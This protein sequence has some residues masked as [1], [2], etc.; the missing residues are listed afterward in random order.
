[1]QKFDVVNLLAEKYGYR[2]YLEISTPG[3]SNAY[4]KIDRRQMFCRRLMYRCAETFRD[5]LD[6]AFRT[7]S[8]YSYEV[9][10]AILKSNLSKGFYD[11]AFVDSFGGHD[12]SL[13]DILGAYALARPGGVIVV[14]NCNPR[15]AADAQDAA[16]SRAF[17]DFLLAR[18]SVTAYTVDCDN[19][20][21]VVFKPED[22]PQGS[23]ELA[24]DRHM[25]NLKDDPASFAF[26]DDKR[27]ELLRLVNEDGFVVSENLDW[28]RLPLRRF[29][30]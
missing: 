16:T 7:P 9:V 22:D 2:S 12:A 15:N 25:A 14:H 17:V 13:C 18:S 24:L 30:A 28:P 10:K 11:V 21:G 20:C 4:N 23:A 6:I 1:M 3:T 19:G 26:F 5:G 27:S 8:A 29:S